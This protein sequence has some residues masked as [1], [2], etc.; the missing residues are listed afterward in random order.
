MRLARWI[1][2]TIIYIIG[3]L[4][5]YLL[6]SLAFSYIPINNFQD[7]KQATKQIYLSTNGVHLDIVIKKSDLSP[8]LLRN[9]YHKPEEKYISIGWGDE[10]FYLNTPTFS[11][12]TL[13]NAAKAMFLK[14]PT[15]MHVTRYKN[16]RPHWVTVK[17]DI[18]KLNKL[19][20]FI[21]NSFATDSQ[22][23]KIILPDAAYYE[24]DNFYKAIG[25]YTALYNCNS[26][27]NHAFKQ[28]GLK[29]SIW[30]PF[31]FGL[32]HFYKN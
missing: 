11:D 27:A 12:L 25:S 4:G 17:L 1:F 5:I 21:E 13:E 15:L 9:L 18:E 14:S 29:S 24:R 22:G 3:A 31:D 7:T 30:T 26:W 19:N 16:K 32:L 2:K 23:Q 8:T 20:T 28:S 6:L 10:N